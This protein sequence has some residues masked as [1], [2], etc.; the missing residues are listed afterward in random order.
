M[1]RRIILITHILLVASAA[2]AV[3]FRCNWQKAGQPATRRG[4]QQINIV[5]HDSTGVCLEDCRDQAIKALGSNDQIIVWLEQGNI[6]DRSTGPHN[7]ERGMI[8]ADGAQ[9]PFGA[10][11]YGVLNC[12]ILKALLAMPVIQACSELKI[13]ADLAIAVMDQSL[14]DTK[15][16]L[17]DLQASL[18][19]QVDDVREKS[20]KQ[21]A[22]AT[23]SF[24]AE[25]AKVQKQSADAVI[26]QEK[27]L[28]AKIKAAQEAYA[29]PI[30]KMQDELQSSLKNIQTTNLQ[31]LQQK[32]QQRA[33][34]IKGAI[35]KLQ[36]FQLLAASA[37]KII[38]QA[39]SPKDPRVQQIVGQL[40]QA[41]KGI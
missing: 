19:K 16:K 22:A 12:P 5:S 20:N 2:H 24:K 36:Q 1:L 39:T 23:D 35:D 25:L 6:F 31:A 26:A 29:A 14:N 15:K 10:S 32:N 30:K 17:A 9:T 8:L 3:S 34:E 27:D 37:L 41:L 40:Q 11:C 4:D 38:P 21:V 13:N 33:Q 28:D 18:K 7:F